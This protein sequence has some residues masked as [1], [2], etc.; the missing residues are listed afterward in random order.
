[1][2]RVGPGDRLPMSNIRLRYLLAQ[3]TAGQVTHHSASVSSSVKNLKQS[4]VPRTGPE[5]LSLD[6][7]AS[8]MCYFYCMSKNMEGM[9]RKN[10]NSK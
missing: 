9:E 1:M 6:A 8:I 3:L 5:T 4:Q 7:A 2:L 10:K